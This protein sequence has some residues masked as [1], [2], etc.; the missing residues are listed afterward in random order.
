MYFYSKLALMT[1]ALIVYIVGFNLNKIYECLAESIED[2]I[3]LSLL[4]MQIV[5]QMFFYVVFLHLI[6]RR[7]SWKYTYIY[8]Y[9]C[10]W[11]K[12]SSFKSQL[13][14]VAKCLTSLALNAL[15]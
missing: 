7:V 4:K 3:R 12:A 5:I 15:N 13:G 2:Q 1:L 8:I 11:E 14:S 6:D 10:K 9:T